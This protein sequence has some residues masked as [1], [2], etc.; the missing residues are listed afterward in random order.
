MNPLNQPD[1]RKEFNACLLRLK[2]LAEGM[3]PTDRMVFMNEVIVR[4]LPERQKVAHAHQKAVMN[5]RSP[6][7]GLTTEQ[8]ELVRKLS[9]ATDRLSGFNEGRIV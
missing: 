1:F 6:H 5:T 2:Q 7:E 8:L 9:E 3:E 4:L